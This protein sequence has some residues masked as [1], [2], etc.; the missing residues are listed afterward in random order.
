MRYAKAAKQLRDFIAGG[1]GDD[2]VVGVVSG[3]DGTIIG[4]VVAFVRV[5]GTSA[6]IFRELC[7][8]L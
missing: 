3:V 8:S 4:L 6:V 5:E 2:D 7:V 1:T